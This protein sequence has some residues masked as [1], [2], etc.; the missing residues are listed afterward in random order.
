MRQNRPENFIEN[1]E[2]SLT[3]SS[4]GQIVPFT[5]LDI[6]FEISGR[7]QRGDLLMKPGTRFA[8]NDLLYKV[9]SEEMFYNL[10]PLFI[11]F[12]KYSTNHDLNS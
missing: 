11:Y 2:R 10:S 5:E 7:L 3:I 6:A 9:S 12:L 1:Q 8:K 4:Y